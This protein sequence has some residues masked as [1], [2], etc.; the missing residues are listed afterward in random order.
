MDR[1]LHFPSHSFF[2]VPIC[3]LNKVGLEWTLTPLL[4]ERK[5]GWACMFVQF[6]GDQKF[7]QEQ[8]R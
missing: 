4:L 3:H 2:E 5:L 7:N 6:S 8:R 1:L